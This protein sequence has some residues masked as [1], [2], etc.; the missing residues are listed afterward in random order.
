MNSFFYNILY[1]KDLVKELVFRE[2]H[3]LYSQ[4][5]TLTLSGDVID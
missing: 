1:H 3:I 4:T 2:K 5:L